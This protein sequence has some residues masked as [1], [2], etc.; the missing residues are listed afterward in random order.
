MKAR[1]NFLKSL[2]G[3]TALLALSAG[4]RANTRNLSGSGPGKSKE[5]EGEFFHVVYFWLVNDSQE[6]KE[7]FLK[8]L[9]IYVEEL[10]RYREVFK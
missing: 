3:I 5:L 7:K 1:R 9:L 6:V 4:S 8:E 10:E 2:G